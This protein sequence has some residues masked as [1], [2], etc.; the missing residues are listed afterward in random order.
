MN[1]NDRTGEV[2]GNMSGVMRRS[3][4]VTPGHHCQLVQN[5]VTWIIEGPTE[6]AVL[7]TRLGCLVRTSRVGPGHSLSGVLDCWCQCGD[8]VTGHSCSRGILQASSNLVWQVQWI[9]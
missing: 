2:T 3:A 4:G 7:T 5:E 1:N 9:A 6:L 8:H